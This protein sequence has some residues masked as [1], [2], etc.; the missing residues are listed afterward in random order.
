[1]VKVAIRADSST[2]VG[3]GHV[4]R[5]LTLAEAIR[6]R[7]ADITFIC[8][9]LPGN[10]IHLIEAKGFP[11]HRLPGLAQDNEAAPDDDQYA[12]QR[13]SWLVE[14]EQIETALMQG[15]S[16]LDWFVVDHYGLDFRVEKFMGKL[17]DRVMVIDDVAD[18]PHD[19]DLLLDQ[20]LH[21]NNEAR[22]EDL[23]SAECRKLLGPNYA[24][25]RPEFPV[26]RAHPRDQPGDVRRVFVFFGAGDPSNETSKALEALRSLAP[27]TPAVDVVVG[28]ANPHRDEIRE[29]CESMSHATIHHHTNNMAEMMRE[30][31][32][33]VRAGGTTTWKRC[34]LGLP[35]IVRVIADNQLDSARYLDKI[36]AVIL[37]DEDHASVAGIARKIRS[38]AEN[39]QLRRRM[40]QIAGNLA[41]GLGT[42]RVVRAMLE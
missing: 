4:M 7:G 30:A 21:E 3:S 10:L 28:A 31:D 20:N 29:L 33:A 39:I 37:A 27:S 14:A 35:R 23:V 15:E 42:E 32:L 16:R 12:W 2:H 26:A 13:T 40:S 41:D 36:G 18:R 34:C 17:A 19:C 11:I 5:C 1:M 24:L 22:Y 38:L 6:T 9:E 8:R 25:L